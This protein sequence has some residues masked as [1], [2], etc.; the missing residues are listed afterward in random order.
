MKFERK[1]QLIFILKTVEGFIEEVSSKLK[2][3]G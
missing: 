2:F 3:K 1:E